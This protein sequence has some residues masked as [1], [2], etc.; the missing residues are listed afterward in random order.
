MAASTVQA[1]PV[2]ANLEG[3][4]VGL[5]PFERKEQVIFFG[6]DRDAVFLKDKIFSA[7]LTLLYAP[8]GV[9]KSSIL[10]TLVT[11]ALEEQHAWVRYFD[12]WTGKDPCAL[13]KARL[14]KFASELGVPDAGI[15]AGAGPGKDPPTLTDIVG[16]IAKADDRTAILILDQFEEF[17]VA[18]GKELDPLRKELASLVRASGL[19]VRVVLS[20]R[21]EFLAALEPF[22][23]QILNLFQSTYLLDSLDDQGLRE[24]IEKPVRIFGG[25]YAPEL[26]NQL[27]SD[28]RASESREALAA[29]ATPVDLPMMQIVCG[30]LWEAA[31]KRKQT[32]LTL[33]LYKEMGGAD[34]ILEAYVREVMPRRWS[35]RLLTA[36]LMKYLA[37]T[38][39]LKKP[40]T[41]QELADN[42]GLNPRRVSAELERLSDRRILRIREYRGQKLY[43][44]QHDAFI[45]F[46]GPWRN[47]ILRRGR[48]IRRFAGVGIA[49]CVILGLVGYYLLTDYLELRKAA[50][51]IS[52]LRDQSPEVRHKL[53]ETRLDSAT[54]DLLFRWKRPEL[55]SDLL[56]KNSDLI[57]D[58][59]GLANAPPQQSQDPDSADRSQPADTQKCSFLCVHYSAGRLLDESYFNQQWRYLAISFFAKRGIPVPLQL[60]LIRETGYPLKRVVFTNGD[61]ELFRAAVPLYEQSV[62]ISPDSMRGP[63]KDFLDRYRGS[64]KEIPAEEI[65]P[66]GPLTVAPQWSRPIWKVAG[67][68]ANDGRG[69]AAIYLASELMKNP[70]PLFGED[71]MTLL[72][73]RANKV[74]PQTA[75][76]AIAAR[77][78]E[79]LRADLAELVKRGQYLTDLP[80]ILDAL[81]AFP[82]TNPG[83]TSPVVADRVFAALHSEKARLPDRLNGPRKDSGGAPA[84]TAPL[85]RTYEDVRPWLPSVERPVKVYLGRKLEEVWFSGRNSILSE[86]LTD[87]RDKIVLQYGVEMRGP[88]IFSAGSENPLLPEAYRIETAVPQTPECTVPA[89]PDA[90]L[91]QFIDTLKRCVVASRTSWVM[92]EDA[93]RERQMTS[94]GVQ[95]WLSGKYSLTGQKELMRAVVGASDSAN[96]IPPDD[97]LWYTDWLLR[98]LIFWSHVADPLDT[99]SMAGHL[100]SMQRARLT[101][102]PPDAPTQPTGRLVADGISALQT[103]RIEAADKAFG[104]AV[105]ANPSMAIHSFLATYPQSLKSFELARATEL[106]GGSSPPYFQPASYTYLT[107]KR[108]AIDD[109]RS[110]WHSSLSP[111]VAR[112]LGLCSLQASAYSFRQ[113]R[114][115]I[116][117]G[118][119]T[120][121]NFGEWTPQE[122]RW[123]AERT[124]SDYDLYSSDVK[125]RDAAGQL[126]KSAVIRLPGP[127]SRMAI[128]FVL[129]DADKFSL[130]SMGQ[131]GPKAWRL[132][133][134][135]ELVE[136]RPEPH[137]L[138]ELANQLYEN[139]RKED[140]EEVLQITD[141]APQVLPVEPDRQQRESDRGSFL[142]YR[143]N[144]LERLS[145]LGIINPALHL[146][147][148]RSEADETIRQLGQMSGWEE[149]A[150]ALQMEF[151]AERGDYAVAIDTGHKMFASYTQ[152]A[153]SDYL[154]YQMMLLSELLQGDQK[155]AAQSADQALTRAAELNGQVNAQAKALQTELMFAAALGQ[156][157]TGSPSMEDTSRAFLGRD[158]PY[159][160]YIAMMLYSRMASSQTQQEAKS[161]LDERWE[162]ADSTHWSERLRGGD[163][164]AWREM[165]LGLYLN[166]VQPEKIFGPLKDEQS[167]ANS[168]LRFLT[169]SREDLLCEA[170][171][172]AALLAESRKDLKTR[173]AYLQKVVDTKVSYFT[174]YYMAKFLLAQKSAPS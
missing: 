65:A 143:A 92:A 170:Y 56:Q 37:P 25:D 121:G 12:N 34:K 146:K 72:L 114:V 45:R 80:T 77:G 134:L 151:A 47:Q 68:P 18:H 115:A 169:M 30:H 161:V 57:P 164:T 82:I 126:L 24:A 8:S 123:L 117:T 11:P 112:R 55:L 27:V 67:N 160:P 2:T 60:Q 119:L 101:P 118:L 1:N 78:Y 13:L 5:R 145:D 43:E 16:R 109:T 105:Q 165:L 74:C 157:V 91:D 173:N 156:I 108:L 69:I 136:A 17:L 162:K 20:L 152:I 137:N 66:F 58:G 103:D 19:D 41:S 89:V 23:N 73:G 130:G 155:A 44:L 122:A 46:I 99:R 110:Q 87:L 6:R 83:N 86:R 76:E 36:R 172:Y 71:A 90:Q 84:K 98:S 28:L 35:D 135:R 9:G 127:D 88:L 124:L 111:D 102:A 75:S 50:S 61:K 21:Q 100:R 154:V 158:H 63:A 106:C 38:S 94:P 10:R 129:G 53:A 39:G 142:Y 167:F 81:A 171:F 95:K 147:D 59:Y 31:S 26:T 144:A 7:R 42:E 153:R 148:R 120:R 96:R 64:W 33:A 131:P 48:V 139:D 49:A 116:E 97:T 113:T 163:E 132:K 14:V 32:T 107:Q 93:F 150:L 22:R 140:L 79:N 104:K 62:F 3:P 133:L 70:T 149:T 166:N 159:V 4:Y 52:T 174:E 128:R 54:T 15:A 168:D 141:R 85:S 138:L 29:S 125:L 51:L 40:Y